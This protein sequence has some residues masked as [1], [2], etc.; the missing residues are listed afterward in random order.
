MGFLPIYQSFNQG[1]DQSTFLKVGL[2]LNYKGAKQKRIH[3]SENPK[4]MYLP[5][6]EFTLYF[7]IMILKTAYK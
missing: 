4:C 6:S 3:V 7:D 1:C 5:F 2:I